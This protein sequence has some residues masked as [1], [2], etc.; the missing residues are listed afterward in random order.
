LKVLQESKP[1]T[2]AIEKYLKRT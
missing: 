2:Q 1:K